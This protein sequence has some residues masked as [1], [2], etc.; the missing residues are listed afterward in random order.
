MHETCEPVESLPPRPGLH[1]GL[2][3]P[4]NGSRRRAPLELGAQEVILDAIE[5]R[6]LFAEIST[7]G[8]RVEATRKPNPESPPEPVHSL[9]QLFIDLSSQRVFGAQIWYEFQGV[10]RT[11]TLIVHSGGITCVRSESKS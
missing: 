6:I 4:S 2:M 11:D 5:L 3:A 8:K 9:A 10:L 1:K 7:F